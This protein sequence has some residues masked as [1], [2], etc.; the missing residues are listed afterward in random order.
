MKFAK[1]MMLVPFSNPLQDPDEKFLIDLDDKMGTILREKNLSVD[2]KVKSYNQILTQF[3]NKKNNIVPIDN[4]QQNEPFKI[5]S[6]DFVDKDLIKT[7]KKIKKK[8]MRNKSNVEKNIIINNDELN[9]SLAVFNNLVDDIENDEDFD[10]EKDEFNDKIKEINKFTTP[11]QNPNKEFK[12]QNVSKNRI[13]PIIRN[14]VLNL[15]Q[16]TI[17]N[18]TENIVEKPVDKTFSYEENLKKFYENIKKPG[19]SN[20]ETLLP[21]MQSIKQNLIDKESIIKRPGLTSN[22]MRKRELEKL[23]KKY[24]D[25]QSFKDKF[26]LKGQIKIME[27]KIKTGNGIKSFQWNSKN[28]FK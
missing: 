23:K 13:K 4:K 14:S 5:I 8:I 20:K 19:I 15:D 26:R 21:I 12:I 9:K 25:S 22:I 6:E 3:I 10:S 11:F 18:K 27:K 24:E 7:K 17:F 1:K 28:F 2:E 16:P